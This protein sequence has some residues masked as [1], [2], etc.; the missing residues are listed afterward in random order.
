[1]LAVVPVALLATARSTGLIRDALSGALGLVFLVA[2]GSKV[3]AGRRWPAQAAGLGVPRSLA[4]LV[5]WAELVIGALTFA[6]VWRPWP[7]VAALVALVGFTT[8][9]GWQLAHGRRPACACF[10]AWSVAPLGARHVVR[11]AAFIALAAAAIVA[12]R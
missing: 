6:G 10:G 2:G 9:I 7:A 1:M 12:G 11:N 4:P 8:V 5:P 3:A